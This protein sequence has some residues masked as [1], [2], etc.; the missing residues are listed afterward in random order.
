MGCALRHR[1]VGSQNCGARAMNKKPSMRCGPALT[2][3]L[4]GAYFARLGLPT[5][6]ND[7]IIRTAVYVLRMYGGV[8]GGTSRDVPLSRWKSQE[9]E[10][11]V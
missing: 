10:L 4:P 1:K 9:Y 3:A 11:D 6:H 2:I 8:A 5:L 7:S